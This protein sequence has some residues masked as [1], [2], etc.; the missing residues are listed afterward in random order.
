MI[1]PRDIAELF[2]KVENPTKEELEQDAYKKWKFE[3]GENFYVTEYGC[4][5]EK[6]G[7]ILKYKEKEE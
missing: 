6:D 2:R 4:F 3:N 5:T 7:E 1:E